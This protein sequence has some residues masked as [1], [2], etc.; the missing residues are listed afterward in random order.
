MQRQMFSICGTVIAALLCS[1]SAVAQDI[2]VASQPCRTS[3]GL[4]GVIFKGI[5]NTIFAP[6]GLKGV[7]ISNWNGTT[8]VDSTVSNEDVTVFPSLR[9]GSQVLVYSHEDAQVNRRTSIAFRDR[10]GAILGSCFL[11]AVRLDTSTHD[12]SK[13]RLGFCKFGEEE[14]VSQLTIGTTNVFDLPEKYI[15]GTTSA[16]SVL[17]HSPMTG[18]RQVRLIGYSQGFATFVWTG[19]DTGNGRLKGVCPFIV[20]G[21]T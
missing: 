9:Y 14:G 12:F 20:L 16:P 3:T 4:P 6:E 1:E 11:S 10:Y 17:G 21:E 2:S 7:H 15:E 13:T 18:A 19:N 5:D 8:Y